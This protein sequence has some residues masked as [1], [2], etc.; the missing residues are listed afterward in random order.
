M[1]IA[2]VE[3]GILLAELTPF[4]MYLNMLA[5]LDRVGRQS[6]PPDILL[7]LGD[8][9]HGHKHIQGIIY[10]PSNILVVNC[11][12]KIIAYPVSSLSV[13]LMEGRGGQQKCLS[14][15]TWGIGLPS[16][17]FKGVTQ[18]PPP[19]PPPQCMHPWKR[20]S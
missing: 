17:K 12:H 1:H 13:I 14:G 19:P 4:C 16:S 3:K 18:A 2:L 5:F 11:L 9:I 7:L 8:N 10:T 15:Q 20:E 6:Y